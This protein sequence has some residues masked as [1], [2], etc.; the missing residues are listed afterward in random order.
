M[1]CRQTKTYLGQTGSGPPGGG[2]YATEAE[3]LQACKEGACCTTTNGVT[4]CAV[5][6]ECQC[7]RPNQSFS[8]VGTSCTTNSG[9]CCQ[10]V[11]TVTTCAQ[12]SECECKGT[13]FRFLGVGTSCS[14]LSGA[15]CEGPTTER[16]CN[17][18]TECQ[19]NGVNA[20]FRGVGTTCA[21]NPCTNGCATPTDSC[22]CWCT[23]DDGTVPNYCNVSID[24]WAKRANGPQ[25]PIRH[26]L[27][28]PRKSAAGSCP[29]WRIE[30]WLPSDSD[31]AGPN[32]IGLR[33]A[34]TGFV[35]TIT[36][37]AYKEAELSA[38]GL[39]A[40]DGSAFTFGY[41]DGDE[42]SFA[43]VR[44]EAGQGCWRSLA[45]RWFRDKGFTLGYPFGDSF[46]YDMRVS[47]NGFA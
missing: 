42:G 29:T 6:P 36:T 14:S 30:D 23:Y 21:G 26:S 22:Q 33:F 47:I 44:A 2:S 10:T 7:Q 38:S 45:G 12:K 40:C 43:P 25:I 5:V 8:G 11:G 1:P 20:V 16:T 39:S 32:T 35:G 24:G 15:C 17:V 27:S 37:L 34:V 18:K 31:Y 28:L 3:C 9:A 4:T 19:C 46:E 41:S 13:G